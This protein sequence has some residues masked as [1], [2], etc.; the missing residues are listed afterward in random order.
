MYLVDRNLNVHFLLCVISKSD[1][2]CRTNLKIIFQI[3][4][5]IQNST[6]FSYIPFEEVFSM[7]LQER[8]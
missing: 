5:G 1:R 2:N 3:Q 6:Q 8:Y 7:K 4:R